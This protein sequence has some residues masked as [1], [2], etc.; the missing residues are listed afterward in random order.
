MAEKDYNVP[1][2]ENLT[3]SPSR[4]KFSSIS[5]PSLKI[6]NG[7]IYEEARKEL[8][9]PKCIPIYQQ[10]ALEPTI[11]SA[12]SLLEILISRSDWKVTVPEDAP[13]IEQERAE[14]I[15]WNI[16]NMERPWEEYIVEF[17][18]YVQWGYQV[19]EIIRTKITDGKYSGR[20]ALKDFRSVSP[21]TITKWIYDTK[22]GE[23]V[24]LRQEFNRISSDFTTHENS[25]GKI[26][27]DIP[28]SKVLH[29]RYNP[30]LDNPEGNSPL[31]S[32]YI[33]W[34]QKATVEDYQLIGV[35]RDLGGVI[36]VGVDVEFLAKASDPESDEAKV[37][38]EMDR[39]AAMLHAGEQSY[40][41]K[42]ISYN[43]QGKE[44]FTFRLVG[45]EG[46]GKQFDTEE[47]IRRLENKML[48]A[49]LADVLKLGTE[50]H[51]SYALADSKT[52]LLSMGVEHHLRII[53][54]ELNHK[55]V[56]QMYLLNGWEYV[57]GQSAK[58]EYGDI[59]KPDL[60]EL[61]KF[62]QRTVTS[63]ALRP[64]KAIEDFLTETM[65]LK[66]QTEEEMDII[67]S[68]MT[69][70][71]GQGNGTSGFGRNSQDNSDDNPE[72]S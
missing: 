15:N 21:S 53:K 23:L 49:F 32:S 3:P 8:R 25:T 56:K 58:F 2:T 20:I 7:E 14:F 34:K 27:K 45:I 41:R 59:E 19:S 51:G 16:N 13:D 31:K 6:I 12:I 18:A 22:S 44:L 71:A 39:Q 42:P 63:G 52:S 33:S 26:H 67:Q 46:G 43:D 24:G 57:D 11:A 66:R 60:D 4:T 55:L 61:S 10:M 50:S 5:L 47:I 65:N 35:S 9:Y 28:K 38:S 62:I 37:L 68:E 40:V 36:E 29:F 30:K 64:T 72:N 48:M 17:L 70:A 1:T 69:S 54:R